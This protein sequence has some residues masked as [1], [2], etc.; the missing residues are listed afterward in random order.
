MTPLDDIDSGQRHPPAADQRPILRRRSLVK[1]T[2]GLV[3]LAA[4]PGFGLAQSTGQT[5]TPGQRPSDKRIG[6]LATGSGQTF[7]TVPI[8]WVAQGT[9]VVWEL[10]QGF[11]STTAYA[12]ANDKPHRI[13]DDASGWDSG[14]LSE[15]GT[16]FERTFNVPGVYDYHCTPHE[17]FGMVGRLV[18]GSPDLADQPALADPQESIPGPAREALAGLNAVTRVLFGR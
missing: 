16:T 9:T 8:R 4:L 2:G 18:V 14:V 15:P 7:Y 3:G 6:M 10:V 1:A 12:E 5:E 13:P 11:H 17:G